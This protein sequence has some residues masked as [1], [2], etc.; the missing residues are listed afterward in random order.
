MDE[1]SHELA[2][3]KIKENGEATLTNTSV[4]PDGSST[5]SGTPT[6]PNGIPNENWASRYENIGGIR[7]FLI[8][9]CSIL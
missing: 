8:I 9:F 7:L 4:S 5:T 2:S 6:P 1:V 3:K